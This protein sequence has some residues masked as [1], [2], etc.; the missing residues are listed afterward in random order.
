MTVKVSGCASVTM[1]RKFKI[2]FDIE[3]EGGEK[4]RKQGQ[5]YT[6]T[7]GIR[8]KREGIWILTRRRSCSI[9]CVTDQILGKK[10]MSYELLIGS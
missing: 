3:E 6:L 5:E 8:R 1:S 9:T 10:N 7:E 4:S 2:Q